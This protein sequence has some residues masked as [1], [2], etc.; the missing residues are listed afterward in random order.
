MSLTCELSGEPLKIGSKG[1]VVV[2]PSGHLCLRR[3]LLTKLAENGGMDPFTTDKRPLAEDQLVTVHGNQSGGQNSQ[4][5]VIPPRMS[6]TS[7]PAVLNMLQTEYDHL[8]LELFDTRKHL[9]ETRKELSVSLY[10]NDAAVRVVARLA[11]E[12]DTARQTLAQYKG[13]GMVSSSTTTTQAAAA[14]VA[15]EEEPSSKKRRI[16]PEDAMEVEAAAAA[17]TPTAAPTTLP[18]DLPLTNDIS[19]KDM[20]AMVSTWEVLHKGRKAR[21]KQAGLTAATPENMVEWFASNASTAQEKSLHKTS[22]KGVTAMA[23][24]QHTDANSTTL[25]S[26]GSKLITAGKD[27]TVVVYDCDTGTVQHTVPTGKSVV[28]T[29]DVNDSYFVTGSKDGKT[30]VYS[31]QDAAM[32]GTHVVQSGA[33]VVHVCLHPDR[34]HLCSATNDGEVTL[35]AISSSDGGAA[36][37]ADGVTPV[38]IFKALPKPDD[39]PVSKSHTYT[40]GALHPDGLIY[41][42]GTSTGAVHV[43]DFRNKSLAS[44]LTMTAEGAYSATESADTVTDLDFSNNGYHLAVAYAS[45]LVRVWD[46]RKQ[47][48]VVTMNQVVESDSEDIKKNMLTTV[49]TVAFD[50]SGKYLA[51]GGVGG[52]RVTTVKEWGITAQVDS[53]L[54]SSLVWKSGND[55]SS[56]SMAVCSEKKRNVTFYGVVAYESK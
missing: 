20:A 24:T 49:D 42:A 41:V 47:T 6:V 35:C 51:Y 38:A 29:V 45:G 7:M 16:E 53:K 13:T 46:L 9:E 21:Q 17:A 55:K 48:V 25:N 27:K 12:R 40:A 36:T 28:T 10:Q 2:T 33:A 43:W 11:V 15:A 1:D 4:G 54:V 50:D 23:V 14:V 44:T 22:C 30:T 26:T 18:E 8:V 5:G 32:I 37:D 19:V 3:L 52:I 56:F 34:V 31:L 39:D